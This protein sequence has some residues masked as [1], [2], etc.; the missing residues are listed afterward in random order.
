MAQLSDEQLLA[1]P[2]H[3]LD[4][5]IALLVKHL[6]GNMLS[7]WTDFFTSDGEK[8]N[9]NR[10]GEFEGNYNN[11]TE[12]MEA[13]ER[14]WN[15]LFSVIDTLQPNQLQRIVYIAKEPNTVVEAINRQLAHYAYHVGQLV[16]LAKFYKTDSWQSLSIP[17]AKP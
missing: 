17:K 7:R 4:N 3:H 9:R 14:G 10:D 5:T 2:S 6:V 15:C 13:W 1:A 16:F 11:R 8:E 12:L